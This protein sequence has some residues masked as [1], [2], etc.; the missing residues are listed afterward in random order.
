MTGPRGVVQGPVGHSDPAP[1]QLLAEG[2]LGAGP[3][4]IRPSAVP[5]PAGLDEGFP[6]FVRAGFDLDREP[7]P[8]PVAAAS[9]GVAWKVVERGTNPPVR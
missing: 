4:P 5:S 1:S 2:W 8:P 3:E 6:A 7:V 9:A